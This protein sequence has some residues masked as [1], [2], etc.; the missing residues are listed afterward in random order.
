MAHLD[1]SV[2]SLR[3]MSD[4]LVPEEITRLLGC[5]PTYSHAEGQITGRSSTGKAIIK[6]GGMWS[7]EAKDR[8]PEAFDQQV[9]EILGK[10]PDDPG[11]WAHLAAHYQV[12]LF[13]GFF[14][15][16]SNE[17]LT[18]SARTL[19]ALGQRGIELGVDIYGSI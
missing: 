6:K 7:L 19:M 8:A 14:M 12:D 13:C 2:M 9:E 18:I 5:E 17:G 11:L 16:E 10:L 4:T 3:I 1:K 15:R